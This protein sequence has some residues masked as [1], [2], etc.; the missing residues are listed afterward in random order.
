MAFV[1][2]SRFLVGFVLLLV[3][4]ELLVRLTGIKEYILPPPI[5]VYFSHVLYGWN[6]RIRSALRIFARV[7]PSLYSQ[8]GCT[9]AQTPSSLQRSRLLFDGKFACVMQ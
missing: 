4:W 1:R 2:R 9:S 8:A 5:T 6:Q 7:C 3:V